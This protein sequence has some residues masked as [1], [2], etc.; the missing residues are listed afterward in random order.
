MA[1]LT[2]HHVNAM[3][4]N[5]IRCTFFEVTTAIAFLYFKNKGVEY[6]VVEVGMGGRFDSTNVIIPEVCVISNVSLEHTDYLGNTIEE[7]A[8]EKAGI[9]K[10]GIPCITIND[11]PVFSV[12]K[13]VAKENNAPLVRI[14]PNDIE[15]MALFEDGTEFTYKEEEYF[16][17][18]PGRCQAKNASVAV[19]TMSKISIYGYKC[20]CK[21]KAGLNNVNWPCRMQRVL[22]TPFI[23]DV[24][25]TLAGSSCLCSDI[26]EIYGKVLV[27]FGI[28]ND[29]D[30]EHISKNISKIASRIIVTRPD[31]IRAAS[32][33]DH[34]FVFKAYGRNIRNR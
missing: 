11:D 31:S 22:G 10:P 9:I 33:R 6:A 12:I 20:R 4:E 17:S 7:I 28:L 23:L 2:V 8:F 5:G 14:D 29:K 13:N 15:V 26:K 18:I 21:I 1:A 25:H 3:A 24:S 27:V 16:V 19:E 34:R 30:V 32:L